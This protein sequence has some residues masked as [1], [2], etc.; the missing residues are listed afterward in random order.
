MN[1]LVKKIELVLPKDKIEETL[2]SLQEGGFLEIIPTSEQE[3]AINQDKDYKLQLSEVNFA[4]SFLENFQEKESFLKNLISSFVPIKE[5]ITEEQIK[6][7]V[8]SPETKE[9]IEKCASIEEEINELES[10]KEILSGEVSALSKFKETSVFLGED[11]KQTTYFAG[12]IEAKHKESFLKEISNKETFCLE[13][14]E[15]DSF[16]FCFVLFFF[17]KQANSFQEVLKK[18]QAKEQQVFWSEKPRKALE[19]RER[20]INDINLELD[21]QRKEAQKLLFFVSKFQALSDWLGWQISKEQFLKQSEKTKRYF[22]IK[23]WVAQEDIKKV[24]EIVS[25]KT[26]FFLIKELL[27]SEED[28]PPVIIKNKGLFSSFGIVTGVYGLPKKNELDPTPY[29]APFF[30]FYFALALSDS[31]Y[32]ALLVVFSFLAKKFFKNAGVDRFFNLFIFGGILTIFAGIFSGTVFGSDI[33]QSLRIIDPMR[34]PI[35]TLIFVLALGFFQI[36]VGLIIGMVWLIKEKRAREG[37]SG[38]GASI[39][40]LTGAALFLITKE[41]AFVVSGLIGMVLLAILYSE[42]ENLFQKASKGFGAVYGL[43]GYLSDILSYSR[44]LALGLATGIIASVINMIA[45]IFKDMI[46]I[47]GVNWLIA[48]IVLVVGHTGNLLINALGAFIHSA[49]LQF[50]E[51]FSKFMEG[52]GRYFRPLDKKSR[53]VEIIK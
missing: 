3:F 2:D 52:G 9:T 35:G 6:E 26:E 46:P 22:G 19:E 16:S 28:K 32:G 25:R 23:A 10:E 24:K 20:K 40:F 29:L 7:I 43:I 13:E 42:T 37:I 47:P 48:G 17:K 41:S 33:T 14:G 15:E 49:R 51:F 5:K 44:I 39:I 18:Y 31:G 30:I 38:N 27:I 8:Y 53:F 34:D 4:L 12:S 1:L 50:V 11:L 21:I 45:V 36:Y